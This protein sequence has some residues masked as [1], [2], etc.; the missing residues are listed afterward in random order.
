MRVEF[1]GLKFELPDG[2]TDITEDLPDGSPPSLARAMGA[3]ALQFSIAKYRD[4]EKP[5]IKTADLRKFLEDFCQRNGMN[6]NDIVDC[7]GDLMSVKTK[8]VIN[9]ELIFARYFSNTV[10]VLLSTYVCT[11][12]NNLE[13]KEDLVGVEKIM[14]SIEL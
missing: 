14:N 2:W 7:P 4:G 5:D 12:I 13:M 8:S 10:D 6:I 1:Y 3:G 11:D 9:G